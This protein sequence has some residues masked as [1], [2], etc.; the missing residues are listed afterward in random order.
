M[1]PGS[2]IKPR[3]LSLEPSA[4][5]HVDLRP[6][7]SRLT[8]VKY[9]CGADKLKKDMHCEDALTAKEIVDVWHYVCNDD[10]EWRQKQQDPT[11]IL[12]GRLEYFGV[13]LT[14]PVQLSMPQGAANLDIVSGK[15][16]ESCLQQYGKKICA[17]C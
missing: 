12:R 17:N 4:A 8:H 3:K 14:S 10:E 1:S 13:V 2:Q 11:T 5:R 9:G 16:V 6:A 15:K 7:P